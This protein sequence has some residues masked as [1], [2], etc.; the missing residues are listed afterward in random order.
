[1]QSNPD[2]ITSLS[3]QPSTTSALSQRRFRWPFTELAI[4]CDKASC[5]IPQTATM[6]LPKGACNISE[7]L[8]FQHPIPSQHCQEQDVGDFPTTENLHNPGHNEFV[9]VELEHK[10]KM[11]YGIKAVEMAIAK[12][13]VEIETLN[14]RLA[15]MKE[16]LGDVQRNIQ[17]KEKIIKGLI[18]GQGA[19]VQN[20]Q[21]NCQY[22]KSPLPQYT[23]LT[24]NK[25][26]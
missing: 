10:Y 2:N 23:N 6:S 21:N 5:L 7:H 14:K 18:S 22:T 24:L 4:V 8:N 19:I 13:I 26:T 3:S 1:M 11:N 16:Q 9:D 15:Y 25:N 20:V 17:I 12:K